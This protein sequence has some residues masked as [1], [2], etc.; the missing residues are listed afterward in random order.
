MKKLKEKFKGHIKRLNTG[1]R[2]DTLREQEL[3]PLYPA[4]SPVSKFPWVNIILFIITF[5]TTTLAGGQSGNGFISY[6]ISGLPYSL[7]L[8]AILLTHEFGHFFAAKKFG[9]DATYPYFIPFPSIIGTMGAVI[10]TR[11]PIPDRRALLYIGAMGPLPGFIVSL[12]AVIVGIYFSEIKPLPPAGGE[13]PIP[14]FGDSIL[15]AL[16]VKIIHGT[17]PQGQDIFLSPYAWAGWIGFLITS[18]NLMPLGQLDGGHILYSLTGRKQLYFGWTAFTGLVVLSFFW[19][20]W[21]L[22]IIMALSFLMIA[23]PPIEKTCELSI[24][25][26]IMGWGCMVIF[27]ITFIPVPVKFI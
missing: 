8:L 22:W 26:K 3:R 16:I 18:L 15:F 21:I 24:A 9:V 13:I 20:G 1:L 12:V 7:T 17:L 11:S 2:D 19:Y 23:H 25:E 4:K 10:K 6:F 14:I 27:L 5:I